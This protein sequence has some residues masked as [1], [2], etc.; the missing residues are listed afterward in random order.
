MIPK[1]LPS[2][3]MDPNL[4]LERNQEIFDLISI[5]ASKETRLIEV[6]GKK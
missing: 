4:A 2:W 5:L 1:E 3:L 6:Y